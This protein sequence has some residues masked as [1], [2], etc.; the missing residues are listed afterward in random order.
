V[1]SEVE[2]CKPWRVKI[3]QEL[4]RRLPE[5]G[6]SFEKYEKAVEMWVTFFNI[7][8]LTVCKILAHTPRSSLRVISSMFIDNIVL[9]HPVA[10]HLFSLLISSCHMHLKILK[11]TLNFKSLVHYMFQLVWSATDALKLMLGT[12]AFPSSMYT[13]PN[14]TFFYTPMSCTSLTCNSNCVRILCM[15]YIDVFIVWLDVYLLVVLGD[16][17]N[18]S[19]DYRRFFINFGYHFICCVV[20]VVIVV[21]L[22]FIFL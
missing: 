9:Q 14:F 22:F 18:M 7:K 8:N 21:L 13:I 5:E 1:G 12:A 11:F 6:S 15:E 4:K 10:Y 16:F 19:C 2:L 17:S 20:V 3:L